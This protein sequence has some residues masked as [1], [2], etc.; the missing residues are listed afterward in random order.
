M[1]KVLKEDKEIIVS[2]ITEGACKGCGICVAAC[3]SGAIDQK[4]FKQD[5]ISSMIHAAVV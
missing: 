1:I 2:H 5:Q 4:G 3:P